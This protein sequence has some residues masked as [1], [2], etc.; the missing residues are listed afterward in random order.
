MSAVALVITI[1][2]P[3]LEKRAFTASH[4]SYVGDENLRCMFDYNEARPLSLA[5]ADFDEDGTPDLIGGYGVGEQGAVVF[6]QGNVDAI[7][8]NNPQRRKAANPRADMPFLSPGRIHPIETAADFI[9]AGDF[10]ADGHWDVVTATRGA[11]VLVWLPGDGRGGFGE[12]RKVNLSG[13][14]TALTTGEINRVDGLTDVVVGIVEKHGAHALVFEN[15]NGALNA[16]PEIINLPSAAASFA[17]GRLDDEYTTDLAIAAGHDLFVVYG[18]DRNLSLD[19]TARASVGAAHMER[20][21]FSSAIQSLTIGAFTDEAHNDVALLN[22]DGEVHILNR[23]EEVKGNHNAS[24]NVAMWHSRI[25]SSGHASET[26]HLIRAR[27]SGLPL[28]NLILRDEFNRQVHVLGFGESKTKLNEN[29]FARGDVVRAS[30]SAIKVEG[31]P[32]AVLPMRLNTDALDDLVLL[33][34][35]QSLP[36]IALMGRDENIGDNQTSFRLQRGIEPGVE[37]E[38]SL[39]EVGTQEAIRAKAERTAKF[40]EKPKSQM[41]L[42]SSCPT[43]M[44]IT[45]GQPINGTLTTTDCVMPDGSY[46]DVYTF[47]GTA[48][49]RIAIEMSSTDFDTFLFLEAPDGTR[50]AENDDS[51]NGSNSRIPADS[52]FF[53]LPSNGTYRILAN[54]FRSGVTGNYIIRLISDSPSGCATS[55]INF[56]QT[57]NGTLST[58]DCMFLPGSG[59]G[60]FYDAYRFDGASGQRILV[61]MSSNDFD[62]F[63]YLAASDGSFVAEDNDGGGG[64]N[65]RIPAGNGFF[66]LP[67][68]GTYTI[69]ATSRLANSTGN[70]T[71]KLSLPVTSMLPTVVTNTNDTGSGSLREAILNSNSNPGV[72]TITFQIGSGLRTISPASPLPQITD[73]VTIDAT[74]QPGF[75]GSPLIELSGNQAGTAASGFIISAGNSVVRGF[76]INGFSANGIELREGGGNIIEGNFIGTDTDS[77]TS[78]EFFPNGESGVLITDSRANVIGG[79]TA[80]ARNVITGNRGDGVQI[81]NR[82]ATENVVRGN[83]IGTNVRGDER[84]GNIGNGVSLID[85]PNNI[86]GGTVAGVRNII[87]FNGEGEAGANGVSLQSSGAEGNLI[88]GNLV[89][90]DITGTVAF[91]NIGSGVFSSGASNNLIG[92][93]TPAAR[94]L[95]SGNTFSGIGF[96]LDANGDRVQGNFIGTDMNGTGAL[97]NQSLGGITVFNADRLALGGTTPAARNV[98]S[99]NEYAGIFIY[100]GDTN[101]DVG[102]SVNNQIMGNYIGVAAN[103]SQALGNVGFG[104]LIVSI[105]AEGNN[106]VGGDTV[107]ARNI[108]SSNTG[109]GV[110]IGIL[111][112][113]PEAMLPGGGATGVIVQNNVIGMDASGN[114]PLGNG[115]SGV[116]VD[117][118]SFTNF[119]QDNLIACNGR[120]GVEIPANRNPA[121]RILIDRNNIFDNAELGIDLGNS[122]ITANDALDTDTGAN[123]LQNFPVLTTVSGSV[124]NNIARHNTAETSLSGATPPV[125]P[126]GG[127]VVNGTLNSAPN[128]SYTVLWY[129]SPDAQCVNNQAVSRP[130]VTGRVANVQTNG[131]GNAPFSFPFAF[132]VGVSNGT[133]NCTATDSDGNTSEFSACLSIPPPSLSIGDASILEG[134]NGTTTLAFPV[135]LSATSNQ[136]VT[137]DY[138]TIDGT[139]QAGSDFTAASSRLTFN[140]G[141]TT[142]AVMITIIGDISF[143]PDETFRLI[144][145]NPVGASLARSEAVGTIGNDDAKRRA[146]GLGRRGRTR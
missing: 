33:Q 5:S 64:T 44:P 18:R 12:M 92:G 28:D 49:Q 93:T 79:T 129:F 25:A 63:L 24:R 134:N 70:Y 138:A 143:E 89:G 132:P 27:V 58:T 139:A 142:N 101:N 126:A 38:K 125:K 120:N 105:D 11:N 13:G 98:I 20:R 55:P 107:D 141:E 39:F 71:L 137:V 81:N 102:A 35:N 30:A 86:I 128:T 115:E 48:N 133:I 61:E 41:P 84:Y 65:P 135:T 57:L 22:K 82:G 72:D 119:I 10:D 85:A 124:T 100:G 67:A 8:P 94:N 37:G 53:T 116:I 62:A 97:G 66:T 88:Q 104:V 46:F 51:G 106:T 45:V 95:I 91:G 31:S 36:T 103:G 73:A 108:I 75:S 6:Y 90:T 112:I 118:D 21:E 56:N 69:F 130:L 110:H 123:F 34:S 3:Q 19:T 54:S 111:M 9:G 32:N 29:D 17:F 136:T 42:G 50:L 145:S 40:S 4:T 127:I 146:T 77:T 16:R 60:A 80:N 14:V 83:F 114:E 144:L 87:S 47:G 78:F 122:G 113:D 74:T 96:Q 23:P 121:V 1:V 7:Y 140:S 76:V 43:T 26:A 131:Q 2:L 59:S 99:G 52:G 109:T 15:P 117:A 68:N